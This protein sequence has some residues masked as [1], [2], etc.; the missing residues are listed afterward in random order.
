MSPRYSPK[1]PRR[2]SSGSR[3][4]V[5]A[6]LLAVAIFVIIELVQAGLRSH[7][8]PSHHK[9][10]VSATAAIAAANDSLQG[11]AVVLWRQG[12]VAGCPDYALHYAKGKLQYTGIRNVTRKGNLT[13]NFDR[14]HQKQLLALVQ[15]AAFFSL[16]G[17]Y[18]LKSVKCRPDRADAATYVIAVTLNGDTKEIKVNKG[19][20]N[21]PKQLTKMTLGIDKLTQ[22]RRW[23]GVG[24]ASTTA[25][26]A[27]VSR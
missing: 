10:P 4:L 20:T 8:K 23:T 18:T 13:V 26:A 17:N 9:A 3:F 14:Y 7:S 21:V 19:C 25:E 1:R 27:T 6:A 22:S 12:C 24:A 2:R 15:Q 5:T 11:F 16:S